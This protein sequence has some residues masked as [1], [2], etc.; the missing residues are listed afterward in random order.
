MPPSS[1]HDL[2]AFLTDL[3]TQHAGLFESMGQNMFRG[4]AVILIVW[5]GIK[6]ALAAAGGPGSGG[7][8]LGEVALA[9]LENHA[10]LV[11]ACGD[12][13]RGCCGAATGSGEAAS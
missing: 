9:R 5:F 11:H 10:N 1:M 3:M 7:A 4:F 2:F 12:A 13:A 8:G 6:S